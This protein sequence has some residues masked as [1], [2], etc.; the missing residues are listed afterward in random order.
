MERGCVAWRSYLSHSYR[1]SYSHMQGR[2]VREIYVLARSVNAMTLW[3]TPKQN[4]LKFKEKQEFV[5]FSVRKKVEEFCQTHGVHPNRIH[6]YYM[7]K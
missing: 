4:Q 1:D 2:D 5:H 3:K 7:L 6:P